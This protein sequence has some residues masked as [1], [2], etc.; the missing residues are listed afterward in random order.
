MPQ[1]IFIIGWN[2]NYGAYIKAKFPE[3]SLKV[4]SEDDLLAIFTSHSL[5]G[6]RGIIGI[7]L[8]DKSILSYSPGRKKEIAGNQYITGLILN[9]DDKPTVYEEILPEISTSL[10]EKIESPN[11]EDLVAHAYQLTTNIKKISEEQ[12]YALIH[13]ND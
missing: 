13:N 11:L 6:S 10:L 12:R 3:G 7:K 1:C 8:H 4:F 2:N 5:T 9:N